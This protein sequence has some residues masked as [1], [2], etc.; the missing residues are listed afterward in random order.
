MSFFL[1]FLFREQLR[2]KEDK[3]EALEPSVKLV[4][5]GL[6]KYANDNLVMLEGELF[7]PVALLRKGNLFD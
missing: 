6:A 1:S 5:K 7:F 3:T 4:R 2:L